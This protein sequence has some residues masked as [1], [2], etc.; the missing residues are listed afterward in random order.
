MGPEAVA[1]H[2][3]TIPLARRRSMFSCLHYR[4]CMPVA[5]LEG[6][7]MAYRLFKRGR[8]RAGRGAGGGDGGREGGRRGEKCV[9]RACIHTSQT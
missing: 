4:G 2:Q 5:I 9:N 6:D 7:V 3:S 8:G 1:L